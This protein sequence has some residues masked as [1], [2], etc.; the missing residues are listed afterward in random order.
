[1]AEENEV[2]NEKREVED[3]LK[4]YAIEECL[5]EIMNEIVM[6]R[7]TN[8]Y[9][10]ISLLFEAKTLPEIIDIQFRSVIIGGDYGV[11][12]N[13]ITN[14]STFS[15]TATYFPSDPELPLP[16]D[17]KDY[18]MLREKIRDAVLE[19]DPTN[20]TKFDE[21]IAELAGIDPAE[22]LA[23]SIAC[24]RAGARHKGMKL[25]QYIASVTGLKDIDLR[26]PVPIPSVLSRPVE[27]KD[28]TQD[29]LLFPIHT[30]SFELAMQ[31]LLKI[32]S[33]VAKNE[34][35]MKPRVLSVTGNPCIASANLSEA[36]RFMQQ[37]L[38]ESGLDKDM[39][40]GAQVHGEHLAEVV[41]EDAEELEYRYAHDGSAAVPLD[42]GDTVELLG[43]LWQE[44]ELIS[45]ES[46][47]SEADVT[48]TKAWR[49]KVD[50]TMYDLRSA[51]GG[52]MTYSL[53]GIGGDTSCSLQI[54][55]DATRF[56]QIDNLEQYSQ[57]MPHNS[58]K[59]QLN[60]FVSVSQ[61][62]DIVR[63]ARRVPGWPILVA[64]S[65][66]LECVDSNDT[67]LSDF[68]VGV[69]AGQAMFGGVL[70]AESTMK[71]NRLL[72]IAEE[73]PNITYAGTKFRM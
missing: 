51:G 69:G 13:L 31:Q 15:G 46:T 54:P 47:F 70:S 16:R 43:A 62:L 38:V 72:E 41:D 63:K 64:T 1:M 58:V 23:L 25:Y 6:E 68:A 10:A 66:L 53:N 4:L 61:A 33:S 67:F 73:N 45:M 28:T 60:K 3:Y 9:V 49:T 59:L 2:I 20:L 36:S 37:L 5:D 11:Q 26:I 21:A 7:P 35:V 24:C 65:D 40:L 42:G 48:N 30:S 29:L 44:I 71:Y 52:S 14:I 32:C 19:I 8:P 18:R 34:N 50:E 56:A 22:S 39:K 27:G 17:I 57:T 12:A 55:L